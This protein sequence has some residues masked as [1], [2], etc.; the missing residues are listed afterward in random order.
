MRKTL[1]ALLG[2]LCAGAAIGGAACAKSD[3]VYNPA[4][5]VNG[6]FESA[7]LSG[8]KVEYGNA[9]DDD[10]VMKTTRTITVFPSTQRAT[11]I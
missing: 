8:W 6:G 11:G 3:T 2:V 5:P 7:D 4:A 1:I 9:F 10:C